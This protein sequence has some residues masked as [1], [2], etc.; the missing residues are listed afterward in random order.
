[1]LPFRA[2]PL[3]STSPSSLGHE[4]RGCLAARHPIVVLPVLRRIVA[5]V[6]LCSFSVWRVR[7][8]IGFTQVDV[9]AGKLSTTPSGRENNS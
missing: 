5:E 3:L 6:D 2:V 4:F 1:M 8:S 7:W 9:E